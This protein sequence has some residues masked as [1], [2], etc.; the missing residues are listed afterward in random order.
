MLNNMCILTLVAST[1]LLLKHI[2]FKYYTFIFSFFSGRDNTKNGI[3]NRLTHSSPSSP[4][5]PGQGVPQEQSLNSFEVIGSAESLVGKLLA[6]QGLGDPD[7]V[8]LSC[9]ELSE[10]LDMTRDQMDREA[11]MILKETEIAQQHH[12]QYMTPQAPPRGPN[13]HQDDKL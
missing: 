1:N 12:L 4:Q 8:A 11:F 13:K 6:S 2:H 3:N 9:L 7:F 10:A 5:G